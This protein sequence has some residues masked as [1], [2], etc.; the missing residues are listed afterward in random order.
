MGW[1][2]QKRRL[3]AFKYPVSDNL[4]TDAHD[5][6]Y[7]RDR[8][9]RGDT[10]GA[11]DHGRSRKQQDRSADDPDSQS[12]IEQQPID[13]DRQDHDGRHGGLGAEGVDRPEMQRKNRG[14]EQKYNSEHVHHAVPPVAMILH[15]IRKLA[16]KI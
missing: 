7:G 12:G 10:D 16:P 11:H 4:Q 1:I 2:V 6:Q 8:P 13:Q 9:H 14:R 15:V 5:N 3:P